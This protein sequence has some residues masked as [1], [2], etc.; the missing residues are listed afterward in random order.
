MGQDHLRAVRLFDAGREQPE[1][2]TESPDA[3]VLML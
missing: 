1:Q 3:C 2:V